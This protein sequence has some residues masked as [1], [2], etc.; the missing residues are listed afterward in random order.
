MDTYKLTP[1]AK[2]SLSVCKKEAQDLKNRYAGTEHLLL[3]L[4]NIGDSIVTE[5]L[6]EFGI[7]LDELRL[8]IY[9]NISQEGDEA[10]ALEEIAYTPRVEKVMDIADTC[11]KRIGRDKIDIDHVFLGLLYESD[12][13]ANNILNSL[14]VNYERVKDIIEK[15]LG[16]NIKENILDKPTPHQFDPNDKDVSSLKN[17]L[18]NGTDITKLAA[19]NKIDPI[20]GRSQEIERVIHILCRK[21]KNNPV[22][23]GEA[24]VGKTAIVEGLSQRIVN[25]NV[26]DILASMH[27]ISL[28]IN[29]LVAGTKYRG[30]FE[31]KLK[32]ILQ[33]VNKCKKIILFIDEI[34]MINGAGSAEGSMDASNI[35]K[36]ALARGDLK[37]V[38]ATTLDEY[39]KFIESDSALDRRF[40][41][42][43]VKEPDIDT[44]IEI[45][46]GIKPAYEKHHNVTYT[47]ECL[48]SAVLYS[49]R[50]ITD[51]QLPD[52]AI[53]LIDE[54]GAATHKVNEITAKVRDLKD[55]IRAAKTKKEN[56]IKGQQF[57]EAC[58]YRDQEKEHTKT[59]V[60]ITNKKKS[61]KNKVKI[62]SDNIKEIVTTI[63]GI[64]VTNITDNEI[65]K[66]NS[67][68]AA[69]SKEVI[70]QEE[71][72]SVISDACK[73][74]AAKLQDPN[75]PVASF[76]FLGTTGVG[77]TYLSKVLA[78]HM[79]NRADSF[80]HI[81]MSEMMESHSI[82]K[83]IGSPPGY[84]G[85][86][87]GGKL[88]EQIRRNPYSLIL[89]DEIEKAHPEVLNAL[90]QILDEGRLTDSLGRE[91]NFKNTIVVMTS[92]VGAD[93]ISNKTSIGFVQPDEE[94]KNE[95]R[96]TESVDVAKKHFKPEFIN[97]IDNIVSF[98]SLTQDSIEQIVSLLFA[99][100]TDRIKHEHNLSIT[101]DKS[102][103]KYFAENGYDEKYGVR[104]LKRTMKANFETL[105]AEQ[106]LSGKFKDKVDL[107][108]EYK[109]KKLSIKIIR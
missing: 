67:L 98:N 8:M 102:A 17:L 60:D 88:T 15:E 56:L 107:K 46:K 79:F 19:Q 23:I 93:I 62:T 97:R 42:V 78:S 51:K 52:K 14:G 66:V 6:E 35:L 58:K 16:D 24:G 103:I 22:L 106:L 5:I 20:I 10:V 83:I 26:P 77:K 25:G 21:R 44:S 75:K 80:V 45:L 101:L 53:D 49:S 94:D 70:G 85:H 2:Q 32:N 34:H 31:E 100:Y 92:N 61:K 91:V 28:D 72:I 71:A 41:P 69:L 86:D 54:A 99:E 95:E 9:D 76:L 73:R 57:E 11:A 84:I 108:L 40:Q 63:T 43:K 39:R 90:L 38:G 33:E 68:K 37:C 18:K 59:L 27:V 4:L 29:S 3:G 13:V 81:D 87:Q 96:K 30:Q 89:F 82:S 65:T 50:Y 36:P 55:K 48:E 109:R 7:D 104:E 12:G 47:N 74:S 64:P 1:R 105:F